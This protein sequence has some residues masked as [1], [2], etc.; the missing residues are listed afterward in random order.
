[1]A[2]DYAGIP[3]RIVKHSF[4][5]DYIFEVIDCVLQW[6]D[7]ASGSIRDG[8]NAAI[9]ESIQLRG[10]SKHPSKA[11]PPRLREPVLRE[12]SAGNDRLIGELLRTWAESQR[13]LYDS[14][15]S[16]L[17]E[18]EM[19]ANG[20]DLREGI[21]I[22]TWPRDEWR[23]AIDTVAARTPGSSRDDVKLMLCYLSGMA[24]RLLVESEPLAACILH[25]RELAV[26]APDWRELDEFVDIIRGI[27]DANAERRTAVFVERCQ[28]ALRQA[29]SEFAAELK[30][31]EVEIGG[32]AQE[33]ASLT[34]SAV[35]PDA[36]S[37]ALELAE[38][39]RD[40]LE[41]YR[42]VRP[43]APSRKQE[44]ERASAREQRELAI[45]TLANEW[46]DM[47]APAAEAGEEAESSA[48]AAGP[49]EG[50][51]PADEKNDGNQEA[52]AEPE[53]AREAPSRGEHEALRAG[54]EQLEG[55]RE[56]L[57][58]E[59]DRLAAENDRLAQANTGLETERQSL[60]TE[61]GELR[62][63]FAQSRDLGKYWRRFYTAFAQV[64]SVNEAVARAEE[65]FPKQLVFAL[66][67]KS[68]RD[69]QFQRPAEALAALVW[70]ATD[71]HHV[72]WLKPGE[73]PG[74][75]ERLRKFCP[76]W[77]YRPHQANV[78]KQQFADWYT[79]KFEGGLYELGEHLTKGNSRDPQ[80]TIRIAFA[81]DDERSQVIVGYVGLHQRNRRS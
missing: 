28:D 74:F 73:E 57:R 54:L 5:S 68:N 22:G 76:G 6:R 51:V 78:T 69:I 26:D 15:R 11:Q 71:Y 20:P 67:S 80:N 13:D 18:L 27:A 1:M 9:D 21:F 70:L 64:G 49:A 24:E 75:D 58:T 60:D 10:F 39:L 33:A 4:T 61:I 59:N 44:Q 3:L 56:S 62:T 48:D 19:P 47:F 37:V 45:L 79:T 72:R 77:K 29:E 16:F 52:P 65:L 38:E 36:I 53:A 31:L 81:W 40:N 50:S 41:D 25:L 35:S 17:T 32:W 23:G 42:R 66:N 63:K 8:L 2:Q 7:M 43:Q 34:N 46:E 14:V 55:E 30:Y 12:V